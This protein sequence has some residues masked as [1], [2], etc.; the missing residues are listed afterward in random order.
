MASSKTRVPKQHRQETFMETKIL[1]STNE[2]IT[3]H[4]IEICYKKEEVEEYC[5]L[6][7]EFHFPMERS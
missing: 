1:H 3:R 4:V 7:S 2:Q 5:S 6:P